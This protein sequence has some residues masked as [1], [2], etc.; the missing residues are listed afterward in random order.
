M[1]NNFN[2]KKKIKKRDKEIMPFFGNEFFQEWSGI[3][4]NFDR[5]INEIL[6]APLSFPAMNM[7]YFPPLSFPHVDII[8]LKDSFRVKVDLPGIE[9]DKIKLNVADDIIEINAKNAEEKE[10]EKEGYYKKER[11]MYGYHR[12]IDMPEKIDP[13]TVKATYK[14][15]VLQ[16]EVQKSKTNKKEIKI[17]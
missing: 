7:R 12:I 6:T 4:R 9:K 16:I 10:E 3:S 5:Y 2:E 15:G 1:K 8:D 11:S 17:E 14:D 13:S